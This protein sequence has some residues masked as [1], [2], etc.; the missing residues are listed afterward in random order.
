MKDQYDDFAA[1]YDWL[2]SDEA[3]T[4]EPQVEGLK[5]LLAEL[6]PD[7]SVLDCACGTGVTAAAL[8][9]RGYH[10]AGSDA[11]GR[12]VARARARMAAEGLDVPLRHCPWQRLPE[13][14]DER[15]DLAVCCGNAV[16]HCRDEADM[17]QSLRAIHGVLAPGGRLVLDTRNWEK[18]LA[19]RQRYKCWGLRERDGARCVPLCVWTFP[20]SAGAPAVVDVVMPIERDGEVQLRSYPITYHP[21]GH[22]QL[23]ARLAA[24]GFV[25]VE[26]EFAPQQRSYMVICRKG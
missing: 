20:E 24:A 11:S 12:M 6:P 8:A 17:I 19:D 25:D 26:S 2:F 1:N 10:V 16:G 4:G 3:L 21:F 15:F 23:L 5:P 22:E 7:A 18:L 9:R 14:F 13:E